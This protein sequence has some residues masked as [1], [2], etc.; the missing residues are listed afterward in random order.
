MNTDG[1]SF[2]KQRNS[3][4]VSTSST[5]TTMNGDSGNVSQ[6]EHD[7][8]Q[9]RYFDKIERLKRTENEVNKS[10]EFFFKLI[11]CSFV[12]RKLKHH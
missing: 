2:R 8:D 7:E 9:E 10:I 3:I 1:L 12:F 6:E 5:N 11:M 4:S